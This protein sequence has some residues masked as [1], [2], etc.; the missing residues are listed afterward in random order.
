MKK[1][2][3]ITA[4][5]CSLILMLSAAACSDNQASNTSSTS[6]NNNS[7]TIQANQPVTASERNISTT[8]EFSSDEAF[9]SIQLGGKMLPSPFCFSDLG[10]KFSLGMKIFDGA[11]DEESGGLV[12]NILCN[13]AKTVSYNI[14]DIKNDDQKDDKKVANTKF[15]VIIQEKD[16]A[17][18][19]NTLLTILGVGIGDSMDDVDKVFGMPESR[20]MANANSGSYTYMSEN[21]TNRKITIDFEE[22]I[23]V[24]ITIYYSVK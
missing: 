18:D 8:K 15:D 1:S 22:N 4:I 5:V 20:S 23:V 13:N 17:M 16:D 19:S 2:T 12:G 7:L 3:K 24:K 21:D 11:D 10:D 9:K 14:Y 6:V